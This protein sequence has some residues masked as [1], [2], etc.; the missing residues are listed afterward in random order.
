MNRIKELRTLEGLT[1]KELSQKLNNIYNMNISDGQ[2]SNYENGKRTPRDQ[3]TWKKLAKFFNV[4]I[5][6][7]MGLT[8]DSTSERNAGKTVDI[9][10]K[11]VL[12]N[13]DIEN[14]PKEIPEELARALGYYGEISDREKP[15]T[16]DSILN[17]SKISPWTT[18]L[19]VSYGRLNEDNKEKA[20]EYIQLLLK[21]Q[22]SHNINIE[23]KIIL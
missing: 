1:L 18:L 10:L 6:Y 21:D 17:L 20:R 3:D 23:S 5:A 12:D 13:I 22:E 9:I 2:L 19:L 14:P 16:P 4:S 8:D 15:L 11:E 7:I